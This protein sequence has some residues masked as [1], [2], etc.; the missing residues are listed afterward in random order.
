MKTQLGPTD[1]P[2]RQEIQGVCMCQ[3]PWGSP[4]RG[5]T[6]DRMV[7]RERS[8]VANSRCAAS[9]ASELSRAAFCTTTTHSQ[10]GSKEQRA[11]GLGLALSLMSVALGQA[12][13]GTRRLGYRRDFR[14]CHMHRPSSFY[15]LPERLG[16]GSSLSHTL[17]RTRQ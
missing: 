5:R 3:R 15:K 4:S 17:P 13:L 10:G 2:L 16:E 11:L 8:R 9:S 7:S 14:Q 12:P 1:K 6:E